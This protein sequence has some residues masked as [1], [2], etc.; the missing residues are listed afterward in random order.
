MFQSEKAKCRVSR[1]AV[2]FNNFTYT[3]TYLGRA[4]VEELPPPDCSVH[5]CEPFS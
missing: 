3:Y 4:P 2:G 1:Y 5:V